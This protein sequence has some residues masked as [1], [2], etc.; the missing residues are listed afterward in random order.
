MDSN[1][2]IHA[3]S[4]NLKTLI[5]ALNLMNR[6]LGDQMKQFCLHFILKGFDYGQPCSCTY[7]NVLLSCI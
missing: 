4:C 7:A 1:K 3:T 2:G 5:Q 6:T